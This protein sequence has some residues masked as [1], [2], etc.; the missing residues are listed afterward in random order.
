MKPRRIFALLA[1]VTLTLG[2]SATAFAGGTVDWTG[3]G[4]NSDGSIKNIDCDDSDPGFGLFIYTGDSDTAPV[5]HIDGTT[6]TGVQQGQGA[7]Q[8]EV[9]LPDP[10][11][12]D[13][14]DIF[15]TF[16]GN[17]D[18]GELTLSHGCPAETTTTTTTTTPTTT[19]TTTTTTP[20]T[21]TTTST[22]TETTSSSS[23]TT[24]TTTTT[25]TSTNTETSSSSTTTGTTATTTTANETT[26]QGSVEELTPPSTDTLGQ[27]ASS[28]TVST[29][30][31]LVLAGVLSGAMILVP[32]AA[33]RRR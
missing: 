1:A 20:T 30:L 5:L 27:P 33:R 22:N 25:T 18:A 29:G 12:P 13:E 31:L 28:S 32:A 11:D 8:F 21:T 17:F 16:T 15:V 3:Q 7:W 10:L 2:V 26:P 4:L 23:T 14:H 19:T 24:A 6:Y 9:P